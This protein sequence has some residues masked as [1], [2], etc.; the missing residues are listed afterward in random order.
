[1]MIETCFKNSHDQGNVIPKPEKHLAANMCDVH[2]VKT[3]FVE[4]YL[5]MESLDVI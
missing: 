5:P 2:N 4:T 1:M 3:V